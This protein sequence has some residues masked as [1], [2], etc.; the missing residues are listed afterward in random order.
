MTVMTR[1]NHGRSILSAVS[2]PPGHSNVVENHILAS[3]KRCVSEYQL[4][5]D[6]PPPK[7]SSS[8]AR[9][10]DDEGKNPAAW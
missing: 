9:S 10:L 8:P 2:N 3:W 5:P 7:P 4:D 1:E 6:A